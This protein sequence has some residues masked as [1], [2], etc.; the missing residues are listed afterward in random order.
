[1]LDGGNMS[2]EQLTKEVQYLQ[3]Q[4]T[5]MKKT[6]EDLFYNLDYDNLSPNFRLTMDK[7]SLTFS[8]VFPD[9]AKNESAFV[10]TATQIVL[11]ASA[12]RDYVTNLLDTQYYTHEQTWAQITIESDNI[13]SAVETTYQTKTDA[14]TQTST[15]LSSISQS[16]TDILSVVSN[17]YE[18][19]GGVDSKVST[20]QQTADKINWIVASGTSAS[21]FTLTSQ[22]ATL[23]ADK[24][25][26]T[27]YVTF[28]S[29]QYPG[30]TTING[31]NI[32]TGTIKADKID[33][34]YYYV[35][36][37]GTTLERPLDYHVDWVNYGR[38]EVLFDINHLKDTVDS[39]ITALRSIGILM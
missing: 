21:N 8:E 10:M 13:K 6:Y 5:V 11:A 2:N 36:L 26:L 18:T 20:V 32:V 17:T 28:D 34:G 3:D 30:T 39:V 16:A 33:F 38:K 22:M 9:G 37:I 12:E 24:I 1:M 23:I 25:N 29:L 14:G 7:F 19:I 31:A 27:G 4:Y 15:F 35:P